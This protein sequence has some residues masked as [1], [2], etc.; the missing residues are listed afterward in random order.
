M[1]LLFRDTLKA[2]F[3]TGEQQEKGLRRFL[4]FAKLSVSGKLSP[5]SME[6]QK[7]LANCMSVL[8]KKKSLQVVFADI[9][10]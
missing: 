10:M 3:H 4:D 6:L 5:N 8:S 9:E 1:S 2:R 7:L